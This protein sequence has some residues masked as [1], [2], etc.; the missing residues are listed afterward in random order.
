[1]ITKKQFHATVAETVAAL[2][3]EALRI[4]RA[5][6]EA[7]AA[8]PDSEEETSFHFVCTEDGESFVLFA[9]NEQDPTP[10]QHF[11]GLEI[12]VNDSKQQVR[13]ALREAVTEALEDYLDFNDI[14]FNS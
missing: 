10:E 1:M 4:Q 13:Q 7:E 3:P 12:A 6:A 14:D 5:F 2:L 11:G 9:D 8:R